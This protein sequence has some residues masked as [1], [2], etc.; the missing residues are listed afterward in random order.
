M[1][2]MAASA[3]APTIGTVDMQKLVQTTKLG[4]KIKTEIESDFKAK[5]TEL[6]K[7]EQALR[8]DEKELE[9][10]KSVM[11][12]EAY[13]KRLDELRT[14]MQQFREVLT[15]NQSELQKKQA[16]LLDPLITKIKQKTQIVAEKKSVTVVLEQSPM[17]LYSLPSADLTDDVLKLVDEN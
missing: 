4:Q 6:E 13:G 9:K 3:A 12:E 7:K 15:K 8:K 11:S 14:Q 5:K 2:G 17:I 16:D 10:K 1:L